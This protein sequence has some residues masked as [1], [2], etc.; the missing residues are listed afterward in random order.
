MHA[1]ILKKKKKSKG[2]TI[3]L[4]ST[5]LTVCKASLWWI[6][7]TDDGAWP[8]RDKFPQQ[9]NFPPLYTIP[10]LFRQKTWKRD[11]L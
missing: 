9:L 10:V 11:K 7:E 2:G 6:S 4:F 1:D 5:L 3:W 8:S